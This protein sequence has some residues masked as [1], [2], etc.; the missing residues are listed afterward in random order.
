MD[1]TGFP[2]LWER[3]RDARAP[4][5]FVHPNPDKPES[6][7]LINRQGRHSASP[8]MLFFMILYIKI[9]TS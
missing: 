1:I 8:M 9:K 7:V 3:G 2:A 5:F 6:S 4:R